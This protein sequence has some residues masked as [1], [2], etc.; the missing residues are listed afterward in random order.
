MKISSLIL[1][2]SIPVVAQLG[3]NLPAKAFDLDGA[4]T[5]QADMCK[6]IFAKT[7]NTM[8]FKPDAD[9]HG[10]GFI[11][12]GNS[13]R[14]TGAKCTIKARKEAGGIRHLIAICSTGIMIDQ[15]QMSFKVDDDNRITRVFPGMEGF[16]T[17]YVRCS[18]AE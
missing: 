1:A 8:S 11:V 18:F 6:K 12:E 4:W 10:S 17:A 5:S 13:I 15:T 2:L 7:G 16:E 14:G 9:S 3:F